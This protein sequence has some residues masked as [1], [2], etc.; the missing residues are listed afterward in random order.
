MASDFGKLGIRPELQKA[1]ASYG[2][3]EPTPVQT[4]AIPLLLAGRDVAAQAQTGTGKTLAFVLP[5]LERLEPKRPFTQ[6][7]IV[8]PTRELAVQIAKETERLA[9]VI[10]A[11]V[12]AL[13]GGQDV[14]RQNRKLE[15]APAVVVGTP[16]RLLDHVKRETLSLNG[17]RMVVVDE[18]DEMLRRGFL[19]EV[20]TLIALTSEK[21]QTMLFSA[22]MPQPIRELAER[23]MRKPEQLR[24]SG[25][26]KQVTVE[27]IEQAVVE[28]AEADKT[29]TLIRLLEHYRP[30]LAMVFCHSK[31]RAN[32]LNEA[33]KEANIESDVLHG[34][35]SQAKREFVLKRFREA[36]LQVLVATDIAARGL[37]IE[38][39]THVFN[40]DVPQDAE[41]YIH[42]I[43]RTGRAG[44]SGVAITLAT[45]RDSARIARLESKI[46]LKLPRRDAEGG[47][48]SS[49]VAKKAPAK[50]A[51]GRKPGASPAANARKRDAGRDR[52]KRPPGA[53]G[54]GGKSRGGFGA[55]AA[56]A[57]RRG[58]PRGKSR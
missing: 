40:Y 17:V 49:P 41:W 5:I 1:L 53:S 21:R 25:K 26:G 28:T 14:E 55:G 16:G 42:R 36:K 4:Q 33:L 39:V 48:L 10:D 13:Y 47:L 18:A 7:L 11:S 30:Y 50:P 45:V 31:G 2:V 27:E 8:T 22:T 12:L 23:Y 32:V 3:K 44:E 35:L 57:P 20:E 46:G 19:E 29:K 56:G 51:G 52:A 9:A 54:P 43:G 38:G 6:A 15:Q 58:A 24:L 34:E 37:D